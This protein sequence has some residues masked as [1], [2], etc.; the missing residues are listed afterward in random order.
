MPLSRIASS[1]ALLALVV[2]AA[3]AQE[4]V[5]NPEFAAWSKFKKGTS[6][7]VRTSTTAEGKTTEVTITNTLVEAGPDALTIETVATS[8]VDGKEI[9]NP[10]IKREVPKTFTLPAGAPKPPPPGQKPEGTVE[11]GTETLKVGGAEYKTKWYKTKNT[12]EGTTIEGK[13]WVSDDV[14]GGLVKAESTAT[15]KLAFTSKLEVVEV[16]KP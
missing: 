10:A 11:E 3:R 2:G 16:K 12:I 6:V 4:K 13:V 1:V 8:K 15:G 7:T 14:P 5:D 9:K